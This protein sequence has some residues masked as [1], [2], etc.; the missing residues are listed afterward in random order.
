[1]LVDV[2]S[3]HQNL[4]L[5][6]QDFQLEVI[7]TLAN[8]HEA[9][10]TYQQSFTSYHDKQRELEQMQQEIERNRQNQDFLQFQYDELANAQLVAGEQEELE[11]THETMAHSED[12]KTAPSMKHRPISLPTN[13]A[14]FLSCASLFLHSVVLLRFTPLQQ[15]GLNVWN[16]VKSN[17]R[18]LPRMLMTIWS[19]LISTHRSWSVSVNDWTAFTTSK[20]NTM[21][22]V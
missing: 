4:L 20:R 10:N 7:D 14:F 15:I 2:H 9:L 13:R 22:K 1:M 3:Q 17:S 8:A 19:V 16:R 12:I 21:L 18:I 6:K 11:Q 5:G